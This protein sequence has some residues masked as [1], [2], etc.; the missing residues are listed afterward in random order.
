MTPF[1]RRA[2]VVA[3]AIAVAVVATVVLLLR[4]S[5]TTLG[6]SQKCGGSYCWGY[7]LSQYKFS[8]Q[9]VLHLTGTWGLDLEYELPKMLVE[10]VQEDRWLAGDRAVYLSVHLKPLNDPSAAGAPVRIL[11]DFQRGETYVSSPLQLWRA[12]DYQSGKPAKNWLSD[13]EFDRALAR[14]EP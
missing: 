11:Y 9:T 8:K 10:R 1:I 14:I 13:A 6:Y 12:P 4:L 3:A 7:Q 2:L 5:Q